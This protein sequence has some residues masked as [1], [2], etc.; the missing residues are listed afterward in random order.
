MY[1]EIGRGATSNQVI[2][3]IATN[4]IIDSTK[5]LQASYMMLI[6]SQ[7]LHIF[8]RETWTNVDKSFGL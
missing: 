2:A 7:D 4:S 1:F 3:V 5:R 6:D 8:Y